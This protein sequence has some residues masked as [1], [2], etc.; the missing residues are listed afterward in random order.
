MAKQKT[1]THD[2]FIPKRPFFAN[3]CV[4]ECKRG[5]TATNRATAGHHCICGSVITWNDMTSKDKPTF[6]SY[7][8]IK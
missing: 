6:N 7:K 8:G 3:C 1:E 4:I 2:S 5:Y